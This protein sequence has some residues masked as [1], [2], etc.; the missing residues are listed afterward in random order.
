MRSKEAIQFFLIMSEIIL[1]PGFVHNLT[2]YIFSLLVILTSCLRKEGY[3]EKIRNTVGN[4][5]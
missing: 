2:V 4:K 1:R 5:E 3:E